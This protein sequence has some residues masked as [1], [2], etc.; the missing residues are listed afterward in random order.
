MQ[1]RRLLMLVAACGLPAGVTAFAAPSGDK[2]LWQGLR[3][4][5]HILLARHATTDPGIGDPP[6][7]VLDQCRT[8]RNLSAG[9]RRDA[10]ALGAAVRAHGVPVGRVWSSRWCRCLDTARLAFGQAEPEPLLDSLFQRDADHVRTT[11][12]ALRARLAAL[13][14]GSNSVLVTHDI[15]IRALVDESVAFG[16]VL[17]LRATGGSLEVLGHLWRPG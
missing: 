2:G 16:E 13:D 4:G 12:D 8:Q 7:F 3:R 9:G 17:A 14:Q 10:R 6:G 1:R 5:G 11:T 15:N